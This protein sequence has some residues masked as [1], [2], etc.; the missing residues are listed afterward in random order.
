MGGG[1]Y[2]CWLCPGLWGPIPLSEDFG[3]GVGV[4]EGEVVKVSASTEGSGSEVLTA[5]KKGPT[6]ILASQLS[7]SVGRAE[8]LLP[9]LPPKSQ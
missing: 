4:G 2:C 7:L 8:G 6:R 9:L 5:G 3:V 1:C